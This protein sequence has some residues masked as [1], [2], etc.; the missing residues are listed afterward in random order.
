MAQQDKSRTVDA[1]QT[2]LN[3][4]DLLQ[5]RNGAGVTELSAE[6]NLSKGTVHSHLTTL[7][8]NDYLIKDDDEY[9]LSLRYLHLAETVK[10]RITIFDVVREELD[11]LAEESSELAQF[12]C[13]EHGK[14]VYLYKSGGKNAVQ[15]ASSVG[16]REYLHC[17][18]LGKAMMAHYSEEYVEEI[19]D[20]H[21]LP[22]FTDQTITSRE[23]LFEVLDEVRERG[24]AVD[25]EEKIEG[26]RCVAAPVTSGEGEVLGSVS[27]SGPSSRMVGDRFREEL[28]SMVVRSAN[29]IELNSQFS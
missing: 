22:A 28:P 3:I 2:S 15:T 7:L 5:R 25:N 4:I 23:E 1:V 26:L 17:I 11:S 18:S 9:K 29:V 6:L 10:N 24:Y 13:E 21:G 8:K 14:A 16:K 20:R 19:I 12:A 27:V